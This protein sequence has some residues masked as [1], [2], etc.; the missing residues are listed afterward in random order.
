WYSNH[1][2]LTVKSGTATI[3]EYDGANAEDVIVAT[4]YPVFGSNDREIIY[5]VATNTDGALIL[6]RSKLLN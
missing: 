3:M 2:L 4:N 6:Q 5:S 1:H